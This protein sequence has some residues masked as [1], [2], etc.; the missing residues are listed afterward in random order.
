MDIHADPY[1]EYKAALIK[2]LDV[3]MPNYWHIRDRMTSRQHDIAK[4][5]LWMASVLGAIAMFLIKDA[6]FAFISTPGILL[7]IS[8][9]LACAS[10]IFS[11]VVFYK[12]DFDS[13]L[14]NP[15]ALS[16][17][18]FDHC[19]KD[20]SHPAGIYSSIINGIAASNRIN[21]SAN[22]SRVKNLRRAAP[23]LITS[24]VLLCAALLALLIPA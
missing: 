1:G 11:L 24:F 14:D 6:H 4:T 17:M 12:G 19:F 16:E 20:P 22:N 8:I 5:F 18:A 15:T 21:L 23:C 3:S 13:R 7:T 10:S 2:I 9:V